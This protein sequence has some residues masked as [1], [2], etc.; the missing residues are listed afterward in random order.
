[1]RLAWLG[2]GS[3]GRPMAGRLIAAGIRPILFDVR[4]E[5]LQELGE[6]AELA[7]SVAEAAAAADL[8]FSTLPNDAILTS[9]GATVLEAMP[10]DAVY[11]DMST[12]SP[13]ASAAV[14]ALAGEKAYLRAPVSGSVSHA[15]QG[16]LTILASGPEA[17]YRRCLPIFE[18]LSQQRFLVGPAEEA[19]Y[20]KLVINNLVGSTAAL[21]AE[22]L[23]LA[24]TAGL[25]RA[26]TLD[27]LS[28]SAVGS[29]LVKYKADALKA[30]DFSPTF[31]TDMMIKDMGLFTEAAR[32][33]DTAAPLAN[34]TLSLLREHSAA[35]C[36]DEDF[37]GIV[38]LLARKRSLDG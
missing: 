2:V 24:E 29:P 26:T 25:D 16:I 3:L 5:T 35:G 6:R 37:F 38:K 12:V 22:S 21:L 34:R 11:C 30:R 9:V 32:R 27:V 10:D 8:I 17:A 13:E 18:E 20:L 31:T 23:A 1:M 36:G 28:A 4:P 14:A 7:G 33:Q 15:E 19:R